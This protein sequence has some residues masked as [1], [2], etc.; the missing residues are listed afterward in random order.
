ME[1]TG[2]YWLSVFSFLIDDGYNVSV[3]N[4]FQ[5]KSFRGA[6][7]NRKQKTDVIDAVLLLTI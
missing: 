2:H 5:V 3:Y 7:N 6:Y 4:P 1:A